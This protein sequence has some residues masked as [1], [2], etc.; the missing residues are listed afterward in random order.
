L[1]HFIASPLHHHFQPEYHFPTPQLAV[2]KLDAH[3]GRIEEP[4]VIVITGDGATATTTT[5]ANITSTHGDERYTVVTNLASVART[6]YRPVRTI[7]NYIGWE[8]RLPVCWDF[9]NNR[10]IIDKGDVTVD[11]LHKALT[12]YVRK[13][14]LCPFCNLPDTNMNIEYFR[15]NAFL[16]C[17]N[18]EI[19][20]SIM[21]ATKVLAQCID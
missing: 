3:G 13:F 5:L 14:V 10:L 8:L 6:L 15:A 1:P 17:F 7:A 9:I 21:D 11:R 19:D 4:E 20:Y 16:Q 18:C 12:N 2:H